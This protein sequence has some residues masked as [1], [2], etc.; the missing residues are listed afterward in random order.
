MPGNHALAHRSAPSLNH[1][2][3][4]IVAAA[5]DLISVKQIEP[6]QLDDMIST[7]AELLQPERALDVLSRVTRASRV[8]GACVVTGHQILGG[9][10]AVPA[11]VG[12]HG[13]L[14]AGARGR[15]TVRILCGDRL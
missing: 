15:Q 11:P 12:G 5:Q 4:L 1:R 10:H 7:R 3:I 6:A 2:M 9:R 8:A 14:E 13:Y